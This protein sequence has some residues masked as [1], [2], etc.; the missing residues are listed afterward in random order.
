MAARRRHSNRRRR[1]GSFGFLYRL[2]SVL[3]ICGVIVV[4]LTLFFRVDT[5]V[6]TG[7]QRYTQQEVIDATGIKTGDNLFLMNK[8]DVA[9][10]IVGE[11][12][13]IEEIRINRKLPD[14][15]LIQVEECGTPLALV[16]DGSAWLISSTGKIVDQKTAAEATDYGTIDGCELLAPSVGSTIAL[17]TEYATQ[18]TSLLRLLAALEDED[19]MGDV[20]AIHLGD[21][22]TLNMDYLDRFTV[23]MP[24]GADDYGWLMQVLKIAVGQLETNQTGTIRLNPDSEYQVRFMPGQRWE[25]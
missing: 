8:Y 10:N 25:G 15:L 24:Y 14:T 23:E 6:V 1:R 20:N 21:A 4:A 5:V 12:P 13:Y 9:Q 2:L 3:V 18:Q 11:L 7:T 16:Q 19:M 17:K 22:S